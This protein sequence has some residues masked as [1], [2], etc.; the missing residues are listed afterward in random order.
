MQ[1]R[2]LSKDI[3]TLEES[4][5]GLSGSDAMPQQLLLDPVISLLKLKT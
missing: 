5:T 2:C 4:I 1:R 3:Q